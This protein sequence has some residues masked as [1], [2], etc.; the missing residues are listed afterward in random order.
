MKA[1]Y[2]VVLSYYQVKADMFLLQKVG[3]ARFLFMKDLRLISVAAKE[4]FGNI[5]A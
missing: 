5:F 4:C 1:F 2:A 3:Y